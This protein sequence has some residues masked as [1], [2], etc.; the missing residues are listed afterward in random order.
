[1]DKYEKKMKAVIP[2]RCNTITI[3]TAY[4]V[5]IICEQNESTFK[6]IAV[7]A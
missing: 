5:L 1:M 2:F 3:S 7:L 4:F 6:R